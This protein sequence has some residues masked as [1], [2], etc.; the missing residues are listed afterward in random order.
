MRCAPAG[1]S[2]T[3]ACTITDG[4]GRARFD[5]RSFHQAVLGNGAVPLAVLDQLV[6]NWAGQAG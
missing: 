2:S 6:T 5:I 4:P 3:P 1:W